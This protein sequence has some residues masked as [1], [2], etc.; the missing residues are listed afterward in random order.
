LVLY[1][2]SITYIEDISNEIFYEIFDY[3]DGCEIYQSFSNLNHRFQ[4]ILSSSAL[5]FKINISSFLDIDIPYNCM[6]IISQQRHQII[7]LR[8]MYNRF[9]TLMNFDS[10]FSRLESLTLIGIK[11]DDLFQHL[12]VLSL[13][14]RLISLILCVGRNLKVFH[15]MYSLIFN[16]P[17]LKY[18]K[19]SSEAYE[20]FIPLPIA[21]NN[22]FSSI[23]YLIINH[24]CSLNDL[25]SILSYTHRLNHLTCREL[26]RSNENITQKATINLPN[27]T[28]ISILECYL[29]FDI[30]EPFIKKISSQL[31]VLRINTYWYASY[32]DA[33]RW[34]RLISEYMPYLREFSLQHHEFI[35]DDFEITENHKR[36]NQFISSFWIS[37]QYIFELAID[38]NDWSWSE[39]IYSI[40]PYR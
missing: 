26:I 17:I 30:L 36:I 31:Q 3:L 27:L 1:R 16:L 14:P 11:S 28:Y 10:S 5:Q 35:D 9:L 32:L 2:K 18:I 19:I 12:S 22:Q 33:N 34:E 4:H 37:H 25:I 8:L 39:I 38:V 15:D 21:T 29:I 40:H 23:E 24:S 6:K 7:S 20:P 13:L